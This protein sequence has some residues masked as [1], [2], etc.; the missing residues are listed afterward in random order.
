MFTSFT[1]FI[2]LVYLAEFP[3]FFITLPVQTNIMRGRKQ[4]RF[5]FIEKVTSP[6]QEK[7]NFKKHYKGLR[8]KGVSILLAF[9]LLLPLLLVSLFLL[10]CL[11]LLEHFTI[12]VHVIEVNAEVGM[13]MSSYL[14]QKSKPSP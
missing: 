13:V 11:F 12:D 3:K 6:L 2:L 1:K 4:G 9:L 7:I 14:L 5:S 10:S 8:R